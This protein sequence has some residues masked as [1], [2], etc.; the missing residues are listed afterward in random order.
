MKSKK[1]LALVLGLIVLVAAVCAVMHFSSQPKA[2]DGGIII[3]GESVTISE[4]DLIDVKGTTVNGKGEE[5]QI[6]GKGVLITDLIGKDFE[7]AKVTASD[8]YSAEITAEDEAYLMV[9]ED[10]SYRMIVFGDSNSK[11][12]VKNVEKIDY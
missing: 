2:E 12:D 1:I 9:Q 5:K 3:N 7:T 11:R 4:S 10:G 8:E 6:D